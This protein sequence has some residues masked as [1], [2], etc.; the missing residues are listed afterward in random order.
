M[1]R[2]LI[3]QET[4]GP[5]Y[6]LLVLSVI[7]GRFFLILSSNR[8]PALSGPHSVLL[9]NLSCLLLD[10]FGA[11]P[12]S[13]Q[14]QGLWRRAYLC[15]WLPMACLQGDHPSLQPSVLPGPLPGETGCHP[16]WRGCSW[17]DE[18]GL[19]MKPSLCF[20]SFAKLLTF[21]VAWREI[22][23][24]E[25]RKESFCAPLKPATWL[26]AGP[27]PSLRKSKVAIQV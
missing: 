6:I 16:A 26:P 14:V 24:L 22:E 1:N 3:L 2:K 8:F 20:T 7:G 18:Q 27:S 9:S 10:F 4:I 17:E 12:N 15:G 23:A 25:W 11:Y 21:S 13:F 5:V 19:R